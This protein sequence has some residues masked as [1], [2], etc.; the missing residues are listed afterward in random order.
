MTIKI[1]PE[2]TVEEVGAALQRELDSRWQFVWEKHLDE[3]QKLYP[4]H[5]D[6]TYGMYFDKLLPP[7]WQQVEQQDF[8]SALEPKE[9]DYLIGGCL[10]FRHSME[11]EHWGSPGHNIRV[12][13]IVL[14]NQ[15]DEHVGSLLLEIHHSHERFHLPAPPRIRICQETIREKI[16]A[17]IRQL[18]E[19]V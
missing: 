5:G 4:E 18:Q 19:Q 3:L 12:F 14:A 8:Y 6:A 16:T 11:K 9:D 10:N 17:H 15:H 2:M 7:I 13:W 1:S